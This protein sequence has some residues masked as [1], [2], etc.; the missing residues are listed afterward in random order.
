MRKVKVAIVDTGLTLDK[1]NPLKKE[2]I[3]RYAVVKQFDKYVIEKDCCDDKCGH[4]TLC[5]STIYKECRNIEL[6]VIKIFE[7]TL[8]TTVAHLET[9]LEFLLEIDIDIINLSVSIDRDSGVKQIKK[10]CKKL[11]EQGKILVSSVENGR[12]HSKPS[13]FNTVLGVRGITFAEPKEYWFNHAVKSCIVDDLPYLHYKGNGKY[14]MFGLNNSYAAAKMSGRIAQ[15]LSESAESYGETSMDKIEKLAKKKYWNE[16]IIKKSMVYPVFKNDRI[17][18]EAFFTELINVLKQFF[19]ISEDA[20]LL[21]YSLFSSKIGK[22]L[23]FC[24]D[25]CIFLERY[26]HFEFSKYEDISKFDLVSVYSVYSLL[27][28]ELGW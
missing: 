28:R 4:G 10:L 26:Y 11:H 20:L 19:N 6:V 2:N 12:K 14:E 17:Y 7:A 16:C 5:A 1:F 8:K 18:K 24:F 15:I 25:L 13:D 23:S 21:K 22:D 27:E 3:S 9:A